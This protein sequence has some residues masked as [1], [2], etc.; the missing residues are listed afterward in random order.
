VAAS[1]DAATG[2]LFLGFQNQGDSTLVALDSYQQEE[3]HQN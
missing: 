1:F 3:E 2:C